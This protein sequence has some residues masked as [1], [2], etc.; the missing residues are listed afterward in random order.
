MNK[1]R[2]AIRMLVAH[3]T[4][5]AIAK[6]I[7]QCLYLRNKEFYMI[8]LYKYKHFLPL[9]LKSSIFVLVFTLLDSMSTVKKHLQKEWN[10]AW[11]LPTVA[12]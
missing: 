11:F 12:S 1:T 4:V 7:L 5:V 6:Y 2:L 9:C 3:V 10:K 8:S